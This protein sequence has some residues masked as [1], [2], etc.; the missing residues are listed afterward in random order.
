MSTGYPISLRRSLN[1]TTF[2]DLLNEQ[3]PFGQANPVIDMCWLSFISPTALVQLACMC[4]L[5]S[6]SGKQPTLRFMDRKVLQYLLRSQFVDAVCDVAVF[7][8][9]FRSTEPDRM[10]TRI[11]RNPLVL[12]V[13][14]V[15]SSDDVQAVVSKILFVLR[16]KLG[17]ADKPA[18]DVAIAVSEIGQ[19][20]Y[21]HNPGVPG[22]VAMQ[23][24]KQKRGRLLEI[25]ISDAG[26]GLVATLNRN[27]AVQ[28]LITDRGAVRRAIQVGTSEFNDP[29]RGRG[30]P[31]L[32]DL[33]V[34]QGGTI[35]L[36][37]GSALGR[38]NK[39]RRKGREFEVPHLAGVHMSLNLPD[40]SS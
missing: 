4:H 31:L 2:D 29:S 3:D 26:V 37:S 18:L 5:L 1:A 32:I 39:A 34:D 38:Y 22:F 33:V 6:S 7:N 36:R 11:G 15:Q 12:E 9:T 35:Q 19:N 8:P 23:A 21:Q 28:G 20:I 13:T 16:E 25:G 17:Y 27:E 40:H 14:R 10:A 30:L 24:Y